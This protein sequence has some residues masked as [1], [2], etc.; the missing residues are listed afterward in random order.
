MIKFYRRYQSLKRFGTEETEGIEIGRAY[1]FPKIDGTNAQVW[2]DGEQLQGGSRNRTLQVG[3]DNAGFYGSMLKDERILAFLKKYPDLRLYGEWLVPHSLTTYQDDAWRKFY[4]FD[5]VKE[6]N[7]D[8]ETDE[9]L[10]LTYEHYQPM[11]EE[12]GLDYINPIAIVKNGSVDNFT[13]YLQNNTFLIKDGM[14]AG[15]GIVIKNYDYTNRFGKI[16]WAKIVSNEFKTK[17]FRKMGAPEREAKLLEEAIV[18]QYITEALVEKEYSKIVNLRGEWHSK[19]I[20][21]LLNMVYYSLIT[22]DMWNILKKWKNCT[23]D[24]GA[25][26]RFCTAKVKTIKSDLF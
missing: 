18:E 19:Y 10:Y 15:E 12:F 11:L 20:P 5:V 4:I 2:Y 24:F 26:N 6:L 8:E 23:I 25:L 1:V 16:I 22:D 14:G 17:H 7:T 9:F 3:N 13:H 21:Q